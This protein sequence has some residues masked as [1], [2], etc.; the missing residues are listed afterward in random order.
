MELHPVVEQVTNRI[1]K[2]SQLSRLAYL[3]HLDAA[4]SQGVQRGALSC[5]NL[6]HAF[7]ASPPK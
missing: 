6:A 1:V 5:T 7:A 3:A 2:L 4:H